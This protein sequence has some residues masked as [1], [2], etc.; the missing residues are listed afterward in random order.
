MLENS[1]Y[2]G[3]RLTDDDKTYIIECYDMARRGI[4]NFL[5]NK[6]KSDRKKFRARFGR[7]GKNT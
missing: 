2:G 5:S 6:A 3:S 1:V 4:D 7:P